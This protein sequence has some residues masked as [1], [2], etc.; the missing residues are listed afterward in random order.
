MGRE[1]PL[2]HFFTLVRLLAAERVQV[3]LSGTAAEGEIVRT[4]CPALLA[5]P[6]RDR[7]VRTFYPAAIVG[8]H[9]GGRRHGQPK[10]RPGASRRGAWHSCTRHLPRAGCLN[11]KRWFPLGP[12]GEALQVVEFCPRNAQCDL[13]L[14]GPCRCTISITPKWSMSA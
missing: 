8:I 6:K 5:E 3:I 11:G 10:Y 12:K 13:S 7:R 9:R 1:W 2:E 4:A 14:G